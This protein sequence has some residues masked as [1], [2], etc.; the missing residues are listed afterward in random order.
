[1]VMPAPWQQDPWTPERV[2][3]LPDDG[4]RY[5]CLGGELLV[6]PAPRIAH[7]IVVSEFARL[8]AAFVRE[9]RLGYLCH[10]PADISL[11]PLS[12]VQ[13]DLFVIPAKIELPTR[14][15]RQVS[16]LLLSSRTRRT[17][18]ARSKSHPP[19]ASETN[20]R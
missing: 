18:G 2:L 5:E 1:M 3:A 11:D 4:N 9:H 10:S 8:I 20:W 16:S 14:K 12:L 6:T 19:V 15:W 17:W 7:A 13:P